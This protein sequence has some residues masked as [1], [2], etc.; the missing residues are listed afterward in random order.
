MSYVS[1]V[2]QC[3]PNFQDMIAKYFWNIGYDEPLPHLDF[4]T[5]PENTSGIEQ[6]VNWRPGKVATIELIG[7]QRLLESDVD[8][9]V[10]NPR[11]TASNKRG[12]ILVEETIDPDVN[13]HIDQLITAADLRCIKEEFP[14]YFAAEVYRMMVVLEQRLA[15]QTATQSAALAGV[16]STDTEA[17]YN[18]LANTGGNVDASNNLEIDLA[19]S[20]GDITPFGYDIIRNAAQMSGYQSQM[21]LFGGSYINN[22]LRRH[23][24]GCCTN[25]GIDLSKLWAQYG[26]SSA[27]DYRVQAALGGQQY[28]LLQRP[29]ALQL[30]KF[31]QGG[32]LNGSPIVTGDGNTYIETVVTSPLTGFPF[33]MTVKYDCGNVYI[34]LFA[35]AKVIAVP[36]MF[37][38]NDRMDGVVFVNRIEAA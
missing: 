6:V 1:Q 25:A 31:V 32:W 34:N 19:T 23:Q 11:C 3:M 28:S 38:T 20:A 18:S 24:A 2:A 5:S 7:R 35:T 29:K 16:W 30:L 33:D 8:S 26:I 15:S 10:G 14:E 27:Y 9:N 17:S 36:N 13:L 12:T 22:Y 4:M 21:A 37:S